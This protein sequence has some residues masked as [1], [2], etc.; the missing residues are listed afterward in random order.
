MSSFASSSSDSSIHIN[1]ADDINM[2]AKFLSRRDFS[3]VRDAPEA[4]LLV[5]LGSEVYGSAGVAAE[6][7]N[8]K[9]VSRILIAG[10]IGHSTCRL[11]DQIQRS[12]T[13]NHIPTSQR[14]EADILY[15]I[16]I[17]LGV[18]KDALYI[19][20]ESTNCGQNAEFTYRKLQSFFTVPESSLSSSLS[21]STTIHQPT[22]NDNNKHDSTSSTTEKYWIPTCIDGPGKI[23]LLQDPTMQRRTHASFEKCWQTKPSTVQFFSYAPFIPQVLWNTVSSTMEFSYSADSNGLTTTSF[24]GQWTMERFYNLLAGEIPRLRN[25]STGYGPNGKNFIVAVDIPLSVETAFANFLQGIPE[26]SR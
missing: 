2:V 12:V 23:I 14:S 16:L 1:L 15:D 10:G 13:Y 8:Q 7:Y 18:P 4:D 20:N 19:E 11:Y 25:T 21:L 17:E 9:K 5:L 26:A 6:F 3:S 22:T 24:P